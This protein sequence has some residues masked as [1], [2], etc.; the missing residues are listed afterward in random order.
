MSEEEML[1][2]TNNIPVN[3]TKEFVNES[4]RLLFVSCLLSIGILLYSCTT[5]PA[6]KPIVDLVAAAIVILTLLWLVPRAQIAFLR[7]A[8]NLTP[9]RRQEL[10]DKARGTF[11]QCIAGPVFLMTGYLA[12]L[13]IDYTN[14]QSAL[15]RDAAIKQAQGTLANAAKQIALTSNGQISDRFAKAIEALSTPDDP[16]NKRAVVKHLLGVYALEGIANQSP[17]DMATAVD[18]LTGFIRNERPRHNATSGKPIVYADNVPLPDDIQAALTVLGRI[19]MDDKFRIEH[20]LYLVETDLHGARLF[21]ANYSR[22]DL[23]GVNLDWA[24]LGGI[25]LNNATLQDAHLRGINFGAYRRIGSTDF[26]N[27]D[28]NR[29]DLTNADIRNQDLSQVQNLTQ[30]QVNRVSQCST[31]T[32]FPKGLKIPKIDRDYSNFIVKQDTHE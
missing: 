29:A 22:A 26:R 32:R 30:L 11:A 4:Y 19:Q 9:D 12:W 15:N 25:Q 17:N 6:V 23:R 10:E 28:F 7:D 13:N 24:C 5:S 16:G 27:T 20:P 2:T 18:I 3:P 8:N 21:N 31:S 14:K 1:E